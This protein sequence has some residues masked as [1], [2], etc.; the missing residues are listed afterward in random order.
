MGII[1]YKEMPQEAS[2]RHRAGEFAL[3]GLALTERGKEL[4]TGE[5]EVAVDAW[6]IAAALDAQ[7]SGACL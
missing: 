3:I 6:H 4:P 7:S 2:E 5:I 1:A